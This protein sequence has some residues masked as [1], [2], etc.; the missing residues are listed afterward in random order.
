MSKERP[1]MIPKYVASSFLLKHF[2]DFFVVLIIPHTQLW[3]FS[4]FDISCYMYKGTYYSCFNLQDYHIPMSEIG[5]WLQLMNLPS[6]TI[7]M[8]IVQTSI[9]E[10]MTIF[11]IKEKKE[12]LFS[13]FQFGALIGHEPL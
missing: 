13:I 2:E 1:D 10:T 9:K 8:V 5:K 6:I 4:N 7:P 11:A 3:M 12:I